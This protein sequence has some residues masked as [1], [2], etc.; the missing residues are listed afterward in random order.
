MAGNF[1]CAALPSISQHMNTVLRDAPEYISNESVNKF[2]LENCD[3]FLSSIGVA[4]PSTNKAFSDQVI[5]RYEKMLDKFLQLGYLKDCEIIIDSAGFQIQTGQLKKEDTGL[6]IELYHKFLAENYNKFKYAFT[7]D[8]APGASDS[9]YDSWAELEDYNARSYR[10]ATELPKEVRDKMLYIHHFRT[11][12]INRINKKLLFEEKLGDYFQN[13]ATGGLVSFSKSSQIFPCILYII[14]LIQILTRA[15]ARGLKSFRFHALGASEFKDIVFHKLVELHIKKTLDIDIEITYDSSTL[16]KVL[17]MG[18]YVYVLDDN[19]LWKM[20]LREDLLHNQWRKKG[21]DESV[22][23]NLL[24]NISK[25]YGFK[26]LDSVNDPI[27]QDHS[28][29]RI[30]YSYG[31]FQVLQTFNLVDKLSS[32]LVKDI[33][34]LY[35]A[36]QIVTFDDKIEKL[37]LDFNCGKTSKRI[38]TRTVSIYNSLKALEELDLDYCDFLVNNFM[39]A[40][41]CQKLS[42]GVVTCF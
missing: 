28:M 14:P 17:M 20:T 30:T 24:E 16:F 1:V 32:E 27:Y 5:T 8:I 23:Y 41:E 36:G 40:D 39:A 2:F 19:K 35:E 9:V 38:Q 18:R 4:F 22:W 25:D 10:K 31:I 13:F 37:M 26:I 15:K 7:L 12:Q 29:T 33:Y 6:F 11:P 34:G 42:G 3:K 21:T